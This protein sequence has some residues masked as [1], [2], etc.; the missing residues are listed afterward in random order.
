MRRLE[1]KIL[2]AAAE[3]SPLRD[4]RSNSPPKS[5]LI[6]SSSEFP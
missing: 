1:A 6:T 3:T 2:K 4:L 5:V